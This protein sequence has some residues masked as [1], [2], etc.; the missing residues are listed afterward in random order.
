VRHPGPLYTLAA[1]V[2]L[3]AGLG[4]ANLVHPG[5]A[6]GHPAATAATTTPATS[7]GVSTGDAGVDVVTTSLPPP[8][9]PV[10]APERGDY[11]GKADG[12]T[13]SVALSMRGGHAIAYVCDGR[14]VEAW[15]SGTMTAD[16]HFDLHD[17]HGAVLTGAWAAS[18]AGGGLGGSVDGSVTVGGRTWHF[19]VGP[20]RKPAGLYR[21][22]PKVKG[23]KGKVG[24]IVRS[25]GSQTGILTV[26]GVSTSAPIL[27]TTTGTATVDGTVV[28][29]EPIS[30]LTGKGDF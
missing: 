8:P 1:G 25:D 23:S 14:K 16:G 9:K 3:V 15:L 24:W 10:V 30:G 5:T 22:T 6:A 21:A 2:V 13:G 28:Y 4:V 20:A 17:V 11:A 7:T 26:N 27:D 18:T 19:T 29:A 12:R